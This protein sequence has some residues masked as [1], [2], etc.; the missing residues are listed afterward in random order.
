M[1]PPRK[2]RAM[3]GFGWWVAMIAAAA[4][5]YYGAFYLLPWK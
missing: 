5:T 3:K 2:A 1:P 4:I